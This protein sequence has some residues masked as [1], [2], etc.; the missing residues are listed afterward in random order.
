M[1]LAE[2]MPNRQTRNIADFNVRD[3]DRNHDWVNESL[4][5]YPEIEEAERFIQ[6]A[7]SNSDITQDRNDSD[8]I[9]SQ[10][11]NEKQRLIYE[12]IELHCISTISNQSIEP[13]RTIIMGTAG[14]GKSYLINL[15]RK[16][17]HKIAKEHNSHENNCIVLAPTG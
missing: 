9:S 1:I 16:R 2:M 6:R 8:H 15:I 13:L 3:I 12:R 11:L 10:N 4:A 5:R 7:I 17:L 14:T